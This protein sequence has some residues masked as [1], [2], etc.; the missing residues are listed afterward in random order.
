MERFLTVIKN[1]GALYRQGA[2]VHGSKVE[3]LSVF[4]VWQEVW[5]LTILAITLTVIRIESVSG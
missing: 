5:A 1:N 4:D 3:Q 2:L